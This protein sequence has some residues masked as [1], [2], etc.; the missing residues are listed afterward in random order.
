MPDIEGFLAAILRGE[1]PAWPSGDER[2][3]ALFLKRA[4]YHGVLPLLHEILQGAPA[5]GPNWPQDVLETCHREAIAHTMWSLQHKHLLGQILE[6]LAMVGITPVLIK[7]SVL[8]YTV[9]ANPATRTRADSDLL[10][11]PRDRFRAAEILKARGFVAEQ[12]VSAEF[13]SYEASFTHNE[14]GVPHT[15]DLHW[16]LHYSQL[17]SRLFG[18][19]ELLRRARPLPMLS[20]AAL[21]VDPVFALMIACLHRANDLL[22]P[23]WIGQMAS[24][25]RERL[26]WLYDFHLLIQSLTPQQLSEFTELIAQRGLR[27]ICRTGIVEAHDRFNTPLPAPMATW[28]PGTGAVEPIVR[29]QCSGMLRQRWMDWLA[30]DGIRDRVDYLVEHVLPPA[31]YMR[32]RF[33]DVTADWLPLLYLRRLSEGMLRRL[34]N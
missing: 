32:A 23:Q 27:E 22:M 19:E 4:G 34:R 20:R 5:P 11:A 31:D 3:A 24:Y 17:Q 33:P 15:L 13:A 26:I 10:V 2:F 14:T 12:S 8:A 16:R 6:D 30:L 9:Y 18:Y 25:G 21:G 29:Y 7:G 28:L 1:F